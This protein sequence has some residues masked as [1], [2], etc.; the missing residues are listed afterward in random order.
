MSDF[1]VVTFPGLTVGAVYAI[2]GLG[3]VLAMRVTRVVNLAQGE[4]YVVGAMLTS[5]LVP[6]GLPYAAAAVVAMVVGGA[7]GALEESGLLRR[8][9]GASGPVLLL[10][11]VAFALSIQGVLVLTWGRNPRSGAPA[12][13]GALELGGVRLQWQAVLLIV[14]AVL[15]AAGLTVFLDRSRTGKAMTA[16]AEDP[17]GARVMGIDVFRLRLLGLIVAGA[18]GGLA[19]SIALP[20]VLVDFSRGLGL[21]LRAFVAAVAGRTS[22]AGTLVA[23]LGIG[24]AETLAV[25]YLS[26]LFSDVFVFGLLVVIVLL[27]PSLHQ[28]RARAAA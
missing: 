24:A 7:L 16:V 27:L 17:D 8:M 15:V 9:R 5:T 21:S 3:I 14:V 18:I 2:L 23:G 22:V 4:F 26:S 28:L 19:G 11:T 10:A 12:I 1:F 25:R 13:P 6:L 20:L